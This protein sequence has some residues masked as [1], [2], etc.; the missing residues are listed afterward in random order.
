[1]GKLSPIE[2]T[3]TE[4]RS[5]EHA[6]L[7]AKVRNAMLAECHTFERQGRP[8]VA[9]AHHRFVSDLTYEQILRM[10]RAILGA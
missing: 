9:A 5:A 3:D 8:E 2:L 10:R 1:M 7:A 4:V 6:L